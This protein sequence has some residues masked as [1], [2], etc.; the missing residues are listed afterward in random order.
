VA[1]IGG[2]QALFFRGDDISVVVVRRLKKGK[3]RKRRKMI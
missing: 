2:S 1:S 3:S